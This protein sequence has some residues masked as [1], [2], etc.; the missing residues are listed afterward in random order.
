MQYDLS[1]Q[2]L[3]YDGGYHPPYASF[4]HLT[5]SMHAKITCN[6]NVL[7]PMTIGKGVDEFTGY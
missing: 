1:K 4:A 3:L 5:N 7:E 2:S 6:I